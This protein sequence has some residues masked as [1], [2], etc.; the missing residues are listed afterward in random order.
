MMVDGVGA[1]IEWGKAG[2]GGG[3]RPFGG[4][5]GD[6]GAGAV[7]WG[8]YVFLFLVFLFELRGMSMLA[9]LAGIILPG[10]A[11]L[12]GNINTRYVLG[13]NF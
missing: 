4:G 13:F 6:G 12:P 3:G 7:G 8:G 10:F 2:R 11:L 9:L 5:G 1:V